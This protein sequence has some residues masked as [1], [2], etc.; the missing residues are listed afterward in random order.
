MSAQARLFS[1]YGSPPVPVDGVVAGGVAGDAA[2]VTTVRTTVWVGPVTVR[3]CVVTR[4]GGVAVRWSP[5]VNAY[6]RPRPIA[7]RPTSASRGARI[8]GRRAAGPAR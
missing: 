7:A 4:T 5:R 8:D 6:A 3:S 1:A 2:V